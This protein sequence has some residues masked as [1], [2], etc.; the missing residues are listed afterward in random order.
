MRF[1]ITLLLLC[2]CMGSIAQ[3]YNFQP[4]WKKGDSKTIKIET[5]T[6]DFEDGEQTKDEFEENEAKI[7]VTKVTE[8]T[9]IFS[10]KMKNQ[11]LSKA[12]EMYENI[13]QE[14][15]VKDYEDLT[16]IY[17]MDRNTLD[18]KLINWE[19][20]RDFITNGVGLMKELALEKDPDGESTFDAILGPL[21]G[22]FNSEEM[23]ASM[24]DPYIGFLFV[25]FGKELNK[26]SPV[27]VTDEEDNPMQPGSTVSST[28]T[29]TL[30]AVD[31]KKNTCNINTRMDLDMSMFLDMMKTMMVKL[32][33]AFADSNDN[34]EAM[35]EEKM[36]EMESMKM[37]VYNTQEISFDMSS[38][39]VT[40]A[41]MTAGSEMVDPTKNASR[42]KTSITTY[43][44]Y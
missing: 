29:Y 31:T 24:Y 7:K 35:V 12:K 18:R 11:V 43:T 30:T 19:E 4:D 17:E 25:P 16:L 13:D 20:A 9:I 40:K 14:V 8:A 32:A 1:S 42:K 10:V 26:D 37:E 36:K 38:T 28:T 5:R 6:L 3:S 22:M 39:W 44:V 34:V 41:V 23:V 21:M 33:T 2:F 27:V 15:K